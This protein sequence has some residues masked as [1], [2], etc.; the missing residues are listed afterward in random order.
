MRLKVS[1]ITRDKDG[2]VISREPIDSLPVFKNA[3]KT[4]SEV[5][6]LDAVEVFA[7]AINTVD[8][9]FHANFRI[10]ARNSGGTF[11]P[12]A[13]YQPA[14]WSISRAQTPDLWGT[15]IEGK[16]VFDFD[17]V[18]AWIHTYSAVSVAGKN[19]WSLPDLETELVGAGAPAKP[20]AKLKAQKGKK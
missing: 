18:A 9:F 14:L 17:E 1:K 11:T 19:L 15:L 3:Q 20:S 16:T 5:A 8:L 7:I 10:G 2:K 6:T 4:E 13:Q 12:A